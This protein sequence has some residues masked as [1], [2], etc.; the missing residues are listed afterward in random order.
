MENGSLFQSLL[1]QQD[2]S[3]QIMAYYFKTWR[4]LSM[5]FHRHSST[6][7]MYNISGECRVE[8]EVESGVIDCVEL[9]KSEFIVLDGNVSHRLIVDEAS[10]CRMLNIEFHFNGQQG[11][12]P[13]VKQF[14]GEEEALAALIQSPEPYLLLTDPDEV[15]HMLKSLVLELDKQALE[16][17][18]MVQLLFMQLLIRIARLWEQLKQ[19][20]QPQ[21]DY[22]IKQCSEY[23]QHNYDRQISVKEIAAHVKLHPG[24]LQRIF[25]LNTGST[26][27]GYLTSL[28]ME[29]AKMLLQQTD[30]PIIEISECVGVESR[31][32][33]HFL[34]K[35]YTGWTPDAFRKA[36]DKQRWKYK[37]SDIS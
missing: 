37:K 8:L 7:I 22:Y 4:N 17:G 6:E 34:F 15:Y 32:Y 35:Q 14:A 31:Q 29:K 24:Y 33:F 20:G 25:K 36:V 23:L 3:P 26:I 13:S 12:F 30:I 16:T 18:V 27:T 19:N 28:R 11:I 10:S 1:L 2:S 21:S 9:K 5:H